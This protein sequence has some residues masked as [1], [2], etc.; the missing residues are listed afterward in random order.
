[1]LIRILLPLQLLTACA[2]TSPVSSS[3]SGVRITGAMR[4]VM[5]KGE[6]GGKI[7]LDSLSGRPGYYGLG[8]LVGLRGEL[9]LAD[10]V[11]YV[12]TVGTDSSMQVRR[13]PT[14]TAPFFVYAR[15]QKWK[16]VPLP[17]SVRSIADLEAFVDQQT[18]DA[19]RPFAFRL[20]GAIIS[21]GIHVQNLAPGSVVSNPTEAH[22]GQVG[23]NL[24]YE[25]VRIVG[26]FSTAHQGIFTH[27]DSYLHLHLLTADERAMG[28]VDALVPGRMTLYLP[29]KE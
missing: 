14:A 7:A 15:V 22:A 8:P 21:A 18:K 26:F 13:D 20:E 17:E 6:L 4:D 29:V 2:P 25:E 28:H 16:S 11:P 27:H 9:L 3:L 1:M 24:G 23:Y 10:G 5:W 12:S 19:P